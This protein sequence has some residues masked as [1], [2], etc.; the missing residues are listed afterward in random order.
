M[1]D[2][3]P[4]TPLELFTEIVGLSY[5]GMLNVSVLT[6]SISPCCCD[7][8]QRVTLLG[9]Y[10]HLLCNLPLL[11]VQR[12]IRTVGHR[13]CIATM[14]F[15]LVYSLWS[16]FKKKNYC[17]SS[18]CIRYTNCGQINCGLS[19][20]DLTFIYT[21]KDQ[22]KHL[23]PGYDIYVHPTHAPSNGNLLMENAGRMGGW[24][25]PP[26]SA[27]MSATLWHSQRRFS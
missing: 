15:W 10:M 6:V 25:A 19:R 24:L 23:D 13:V 21:S 7:I 16:R 14:G 12:I 27:G 8:F 9:L 2:D 4:F 18:A 1:D 5:T 22:R 11:C 17:S 3:V 26:T 20:E